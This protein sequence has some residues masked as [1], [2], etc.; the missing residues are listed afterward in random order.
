LGD[1][2]VH[3]VLQE[4]ADRPKA[5]YMVARKG[6]VVVAVGDEEL[7]LDPSFPAEKLASLKLTKDE[8]IQKL[9]A[10]LAAPAP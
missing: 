1:E 4:A 7:V 10:W 9:V 3:V 5:E 2:A 6:A 8:K